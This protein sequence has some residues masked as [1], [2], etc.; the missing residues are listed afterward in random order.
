MTLLG[1]SV[2][3]E[4]AS[5]RWFIRADLKHTLTGDLRKKVWLENKL[6]GS[7]GGEG[8]RERRDGG[9]YHV[10]GEA[11]TRVLLPTAQ[12]QSYQRLQEARHMPSL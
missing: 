9:D 8:K 11:G 4:A 3:A 6:T 2:F 7:G 1:N 10:M 5:L 12:H